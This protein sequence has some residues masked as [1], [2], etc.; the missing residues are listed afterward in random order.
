MTI[1]SNQ[2]TVISGLGN[3]Q[4]LIPYLAVG[5]CWCLVAIAGLSIRLTT[6][7]WRPVFDWAFTQGILLEKAIPNIQKWP[8]RAI[9]MAVY[10]LVG[11]IAW[12]AIE[13]SRRH[14]PNHVWRRALISWLVIQLTYSVA[15]VILV[16]KGI[17]AE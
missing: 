15:M 2:P 17:V 12:A 10:G 13:R 9:L 16:G 11:V 6:P 3:D 7:A 1:D 14:S 8:G 4:G 5:A